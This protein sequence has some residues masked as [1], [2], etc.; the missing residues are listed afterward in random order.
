MSFCVAL[1]S[2]TLS[3]GLSLAHEADGAAAHQTE[4]LDRAAQGPFLTVGAGRW[5]K[6]R[7]SVREGLGG[8]GFPQ[9]QSVQY[10]EENI[11]FCICTTHASTNHFRE[12]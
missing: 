3:V 10:S 5:K 9:E 12:V 8:P 6:D 11:T 7:Q 4:L 1:P 2:A